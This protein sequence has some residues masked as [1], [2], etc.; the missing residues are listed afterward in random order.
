MVF[1]GSQQETL[2]LDG[3]LLVSQD[4]KNTEYVFLIFTCSY[5]FGRDDLDVLGLTFQKELLIYTKCLWPNHSLIIDKQLP[6]YNNINKQ[7]QNTWKNKFKRKIKKKIESIEEISSIVLSDD[8]YGIFSQTLTMNDLSPFQLKLINKCNQHTI[9]FRIF[10]PP[11][12][13]PSSVAIQ[14]TQGSNNKK[15]SSYSIISSIGSNSSSSNNIKT[16]WN[17][18]LSC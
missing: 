8:S 16:E 1:E 17:L 18:I 10:L 11:S 7:N 15:Q 14:T 9:P 5:R 2:D 6:I 4:I 13:S 3:V 12:I